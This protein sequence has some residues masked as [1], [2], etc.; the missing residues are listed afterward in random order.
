[1]NRLVA[2][3]CIGALS[4]AFVGCDSGSDRLSQEE[5]LE[6][7]NEICAEGSDEI[8]AIFEE[9][10]PED[11]EEPSA[12]EIAEVFEEEF[13]PNIRGQIEDLRELEP[14]EDVEDDLNQVLDDAE[15]ALD[16]AEE[17]IQDDPETFLQS[18]ED[19]FSDVNEQMEEIGLDECSE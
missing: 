18:S 5:F 7:G 1:M 2:S 14:P 16:D 3:A 8:D 15:E 11:S 6:Q 19:I 17:Q 9:A 13:I 10:F 4:A 12:E